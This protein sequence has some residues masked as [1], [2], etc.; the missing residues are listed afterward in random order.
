MRYIC[1]WLA[2]VA[3]CHP[4]VFSMTWCSS[5]WQVAK[6]PLLPPAVL[7][8]SWTHLVLTST[9]STEKTS[10]D[11]SYGQESDRHGIRCA[12]VRAI[13]LLFRL[14]LCFDGFKQFKANFVVNE[15]ELLLEVDYSCLY[16]V[17]AQ[18]C[19]YS[20][21]HGASI[22]YRLIVIKISSTSKCLNA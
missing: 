20:R 8:W 6:R 13:A 17:H 7:H 22:C 18:I 14:P 12:A 21:L 5:S 15:H 1:R 19:V 10:G 2:C 4:Q 11:K 9:A 16:S 3:S